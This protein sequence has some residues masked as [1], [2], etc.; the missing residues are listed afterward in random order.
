[1]E[2]TTGTQ[3]A[4]PGTQQT[5]PN[6]TAVLVLGILSIVFCWCTGVPGI[7]MGIIAIVLS[8]KSKS[9]FTNNPGMYSEISYKNMNAG[10][11]CGIIGLIFSSIYFIYAI[12]KWIIVGGVLFAIFSEFPWESL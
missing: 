11:I 4:Y 1:M 12:I 5:L 10:R 8:N 7:A 6:S 2:N 3:Q 9:L